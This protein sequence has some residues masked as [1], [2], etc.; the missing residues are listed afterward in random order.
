MAGDDILQPFSPISSQRLVYRRSTFVLAAGATLPVAFQFQQLKVISCT[1][2]TAIFAAIG[3]STDEVPMAVGLGYGV[4]QAEL[5][6]AKF[7]NALTLRNASGAP[8]TITI[9]FAFGN[10]TDDR[11]TIGGS[12]S[13]TGSIVDVQGGTANSITKAEDSPHSSGD[14]GVMSLGVRNDFLGSAATSANTDY[15]HHSIDARGA[16]F[17]KPAQRSISTSQVN[18]L[19]TATQIITAA[20]ANGEILISSGT[21]DLWIGGTSGVTTANGFL[22]PAGSTMS[23]NGNMGDIYGIRTGSAGTAYA[24]VGSNA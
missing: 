1:D 23:L 22:I 5:D 9:A 8:V 18:V 12:I 3:Y 24:L 11:V 6:L 15:G 19:T 2:D 20:A 10:I 7:Y 16:L 21:T 14:A 17:V 4:T 13:V